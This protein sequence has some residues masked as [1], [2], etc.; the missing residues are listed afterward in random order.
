[1]VGSIVTKLGQIA[2]SVSE[3]NL[4]LPAFGPFEYKVL[5]YVSCAAIIALIY[6]VI[7][8]VKV[9]A[10]PSGPK[11]LTDVADAIEQGSMA[12]LKQQSKIMSM[13]VLIVFV[14][15][16]SM[17]YFGTFRDDPKR[18]ELSWGIAL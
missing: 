1:M 8:V 2:M 17:Y 12:Y 6:G 10:Q 5:T 11:A 14:T 18:I 9:M 13:F 3:A 15:L 16:L 7:L 4:V